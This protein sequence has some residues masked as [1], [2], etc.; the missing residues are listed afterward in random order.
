[1]ADQSVLARV[2]FLA[3]I[4]VR[5]ALFPVWLLLLL[6]ELVAR[7]VWGFIFSE[8]WFPRMSFLEWAS[9]SWRGALMNWPMWY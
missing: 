5:A 4:P 9:T 3:L 6:A 8:D 1:M 7:L 2:V